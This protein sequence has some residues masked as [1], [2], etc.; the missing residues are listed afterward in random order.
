M[1]EGLSTLVPR[2]VW[3]AAH[4]L[5]HDALLLCFALQAIRHISA[6]V[7]MAVIKAAAEEGHVC[8][9]VQAPL[10]AG[11]GALLDWIKQRMFVPK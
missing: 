2:T 5:L 4:S 1:G 9:A 7:A 3:R 11:D 10:A 8:D 6:T